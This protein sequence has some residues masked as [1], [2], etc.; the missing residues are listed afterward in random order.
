MD[1]EVV[2]HLLELREIN[3]TFMTGLDAAVHAME[4]WDGLSEERKESMISALKKIMDQSEEMQKLI[5]QNEEAYGERTRR[6]I[7]ARMK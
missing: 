7:E 4:K 1:D 2:K 6:S 5:V 3:E